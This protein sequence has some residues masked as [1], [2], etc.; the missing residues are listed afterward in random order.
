MIGQVDA[1]LRVGL[2]GR[3]LEWSGDNF[4]VLEEKFRRDSATEFTGS[5]HFA[6]L[7]YPFRFSA[8]WPGLSFS[9]HNDAKTVG[10]QM[11]GTMIKRDQKRGRTK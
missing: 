5:F 8:F 7:L 3:R 6:L 9:G 4:G 11:D 2:L 10:E 1:I